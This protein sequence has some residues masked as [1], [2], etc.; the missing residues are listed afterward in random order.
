MAAR[1]K[2]EQMMSETKLEN[3]GQFLSLHSFLIAGYAPSVQSKTDH[4]HPTI[5]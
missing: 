2:K 1:F 3:Q 5:E 4:F